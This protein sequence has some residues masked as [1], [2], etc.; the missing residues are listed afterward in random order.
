MEQKYDVFISYSRKDY[1]DENKNVIPGNVISKIKDKLSEAGISYWID[2]EGIKH[3]DDFVEKIVSHI[4]QSEIFLYISS[5]NANKSSWTC[6]EIASADE[7]NK[8]IIPIRVDKSKY[9]AKVLFRIADLDYIEYYVNEEKAL[10]ELVDSIKAYLENLEI[11]KQQREQELQRLLLQREKEQK[12]L[13][14]HIENS[15]KKLDNDRKKIELELNNLLLDIEKVLDENKRVELVLLVKSKV[16]NIPEDVGQIQDENISLKH[17]KSELNKALLNTKKEL[18]QVKSLVGGNPK[19]KIKWIRIIYNTVIVF[20]ILSLLFCLY[21][22]GHIDNRRE[23]WEK[24]YDEMYEEALSLAKKVDTLNTTLSL[25]RVSISSPAEGTT[26]KIVVSSNREWD[27]LHATSDFYSVTRKGDALTV[28]VKANLSSKTRYDYF[29]VTTKDGRKQQKVTV[30]CE[31]VSTV[32]NE[33]TL[34]VSQSD[35]YFEA[36]GGTKTI[37]V[38]CSTDWSVGLEIRGWVHLT[39]NGN[40]LTIQVDA[41][42]KFNS[43][44]DYFLIQ[45]GGKTKI[46]NI[47]QDGNS[48]IADATV[49]SIW[50]IHNIH[51]D[52][53]GNGMEI[54]IKMK[55]YNLKNKNCR[56]SAYFYTSSGEE[57]K[58]TNGLYNTDDNQVSCGKDFCPTYDN[59]E[60]KDF[61]LFMPYRELHINENK[62]LKFIVI[63]WNR[64][65]SPSV[66]L[67]TSDWRYFN[68]WLTSKNDQYCY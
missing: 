6:K 20:L 1:V 52:W 42:N 58:D 27:L 24:R 62:S 63:L 14:A 23:Y 5:A 48:S 67:S 54:H 15:I 22:I 49:D 64:S 11:E 39:R 9:N 44:K 41:N 51:R 56:A 53:D 25:S 46:I 45:A 17:E 61:V 16:A 36:S 21:C 31:G 55:A 33:A 2:E 8:H 32:P 4:E 30:K 10:Q 26:A 57:L 43:R 37:T 7:L 18:E 3:G 13:I 66:D 38:S 19:N 50:V 34:S 59:C 29:Y 28:V 40:R 68:Y 60:Y 35:L 12:E 47:H 65:V